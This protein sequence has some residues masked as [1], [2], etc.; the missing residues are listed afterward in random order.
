[1]FSAFTGKPFDIDAL[2]AS[3]PDAPRFEG[4]YKKDPK[5]DQW[6]SDIEAGCVERKVP[7]KH[8]HAVAQRYMGKRACDR[9]YEV[10]KVMME[11]GLS[12]SSLR[13]LF[14][15]KFSYSPGQDNFPAI[16]IRD[17]S[18]GVQYELEDMDEVKEKCLL[19][20]NIERKRALCF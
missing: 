14:V 19:S 6:L 10:K 4:I 17:P 13:V 15:D 8:W 9:L 2:C 12:F 3:W 20:L 16:Y 7:K 18:S 5:V 1:M 11:P